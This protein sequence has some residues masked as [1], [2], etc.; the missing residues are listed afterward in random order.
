M[1]V[2]IGEHS[3]ADLSSQMTCGDKDFRFMAVNDLMAELNR[4]AIQLDAESERR[5]VH[6]LLNLLEDKNI[7]VQNLSV[8]WLVLKV[9]GGRPIGRR[10]GRN[11]F[12]RSAGDRFSQ[13]GRMEYNRI[14]LH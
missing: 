10:S 9:V 6:M 8:K 11:P 2:R 7:E 4:D 3:S 5:V 12:A 13:F 1:A 14:K